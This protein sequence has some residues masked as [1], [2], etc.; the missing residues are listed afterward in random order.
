MDHFIAVLSA[1]GCS[2]LSWCRLKAEGR[3]KVQTGKEYFRFEFGFCLAA[4]PQ[5]TDNQTSL[6]S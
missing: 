2:L 6:I 5:P 4:S 1:I 3:V